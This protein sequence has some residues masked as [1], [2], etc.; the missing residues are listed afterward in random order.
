[1]ETITAV[2]VVFY[3]E[4]GAA[5][6]KEMYEVLEDTVKITVPKNIAHALVHNYDTG[7]FICK[8]TK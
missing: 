3:G 1:M 5:I 6:N 4:D 8:I 7:K 2:E